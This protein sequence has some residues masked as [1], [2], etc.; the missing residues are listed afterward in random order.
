MVK[1][2][3]SFKNTTI[4]DFLDMVAE[5][6]PPL[7]AGGCAAALCGAVAVSLGILI[8]R[9]VIRRSTDSLDKKALQHILNDLLVFQKTYLDLMDEDQAAYEKVIEGIHNLKYSGGIIG[10][11]EESLQEAYLISIKPPMALIETSV[12]MLRLFQILSAKIHEPLKADMT[13][14]VESASACFNGSFM[15]AK[16]NVKK[17]EISET[18]SALMRQLNIY[19]LEFESIMKFFNKCNE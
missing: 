4:S 18:V 10:Q 13:V 12:R 7:P 19:R 5:D 14:A 9:V 2:S 6:V 3:L 1:I 16:E 8:T 11:K 15:I 17:I